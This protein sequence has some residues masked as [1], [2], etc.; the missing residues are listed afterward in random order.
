VA[1][2]TLMPSLVTMGTTRRSSR[3]LNGTTSWAQTYSASRS[4]I[5]LWPTRRYT[6]TTF[7]TVLVALSSHRLHISRATSRCAIV[8][9]WILL[10]CTRDPTVSSRLILNPLNRSP[11]RVFLPP[12]SPT[13]PTAFNTPRA[14]FTLRRLGAPL[15]PLLLPLPLPRAV[16][17]LSRVSRRV[18]RVRMEAADHRLPRVR[19]VARPCVA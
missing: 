6:A 13:P 14:C 19:R 10:E 12:G 7:S 18:P 17:A 1:W 5:L 9:T 4:V 16:Q 2:S 3:L 11:L 8:T 15:A